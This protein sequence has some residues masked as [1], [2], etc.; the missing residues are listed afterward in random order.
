[1]SDNLKITIHILLSTVSIGYLTY[2]ASIY[3]ENKVL[4]STIVIFNII[5]ILDV[6]FRM[7]KMRKNRI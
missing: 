3:S 4:L 5:I 6:V 2:L 1:M 7:R